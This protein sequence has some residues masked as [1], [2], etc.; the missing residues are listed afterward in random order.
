MQRPRFILASASPARRRLLQGAGID[1][2]VM[3]SDF[4]EDQIVMNNAAELVQSLARGKAEAIAA[5]L[6]QDNPDW[7]VLG[8]DSVLALHGEIH[9]KPAHAQEAIARWQ[10]MR[11]RVGELYTGHVLIDGRQGKTLSRSQMT[12]VQFAKVSDR[13]IAAYVATGEPL[14]CAGCFALEG[15]GGF[16]VEQLVGCHT[17]VIGLSLPL[18]RSML[19][20]LDYDI[21]D[22]WQS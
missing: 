5:Q 22:F 8:C 2:V 17:N 18:L 16:F 20:D 13:Q 7:L 9:G 1:P 21:I 4:D 3:P 10:Q 12:Q 15:Q 14:N 19:A 6:P 11:G